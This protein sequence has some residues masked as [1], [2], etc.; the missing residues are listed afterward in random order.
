MREARRIDQWLWFAR[1][2]KSRSLAQRLVADGAVRINKAKVVRASAE[3]APDDIVTIAVHGRIRVLKVRGLG[4]RRGPSAEAL[5]LYE[6]LTV[7]GPAH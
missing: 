5:G 1:I 3:V 4:A 2:V 7:S 6:E